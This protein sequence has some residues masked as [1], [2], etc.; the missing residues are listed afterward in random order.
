MSRPTKF[1]REQVLQQAMQAFWQRGYAA[2]SVR[3]LVEA[4]G[5]LPGSLYA[6]FGGKRGLFLASLDLYFG[7]SRRRL[8]ATLG[9]DGALYYLS[10]GTGS[11][12]RIAYT[13]PTPVEPGSFGEV[14][15]RFD[16][17]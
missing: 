16:Q 1:D 7:N 13:G 3:D 2:T 10:Q 6:T 12:F 14:K 15:A 11:I 8:D 5:L 4:T 9:A 17:E